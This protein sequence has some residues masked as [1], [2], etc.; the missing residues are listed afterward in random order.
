V[1]GLPLLVQPP[2]DADHYGQKVDVAGERELNDH[3]ERRSPT[4]YDRGGGVRRSGWS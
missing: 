1:E 2:R 4:G 3:V